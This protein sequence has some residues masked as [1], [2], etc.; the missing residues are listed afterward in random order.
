MKAVYIQPQLEVFA[1]AAEAGFAISQPHGGELG[2]DSPDLRTMS[3][4]AHSEQTL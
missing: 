2:P 3:T 1:V 4:N